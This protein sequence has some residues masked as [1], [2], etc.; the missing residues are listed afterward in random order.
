M[1]GDVTIA[2][3][4]DTLSVA[5]CGRLLADAGARVIRL[6]PGEPGPLES[7]DPDYAAYL[8]S[9]K[10]RAARSGPGLSG[11]VAQADVAVCDSKAAFGVMPKPRTVWAASSVISAICSAV[12]SGFICVSHMNNAPAC[13]IRQERA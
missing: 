13:R 4:G 5:Y 10:Q 9:G 1:L 2:E 7:E 11:V 6:E 8:H 3:I 12:G